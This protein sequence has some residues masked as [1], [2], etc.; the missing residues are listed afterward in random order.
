MK[1]AAWVKRALPIAAIVL[2]KGAGGEHKIVEYTPLTVTLCECGYGCVGRASGRVKK[3]LGGGATLEE[4]LELIQGC[5]GVNG[6]RLRVE[7]EQESGV[8]TFVEEANG[9]A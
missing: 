6:E 7:V 3:L 8:R 1:R 4:V 5:Q 2:H 9:Y